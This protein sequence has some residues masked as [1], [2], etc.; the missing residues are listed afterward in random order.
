GPLAGMVEQV[1]NWNEP[2]SS[3]NTNDPPL[4]NWAPNSGIQQKALWQIGSSRVIDVATVQ[5]HSGSL[6]Q[7]EADLR[8]VA[9]HLEG[10]DNRIAWHLYPRGGV[11][12]NL[13]QQFRDLYAQVLGDYP[14]TCTEAGYF[15]AVN[16]TGGAIK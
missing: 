5:L 2:N 12:A 13:V 3:R 8:L 7:H 16:Y 6:T 10:Y 4:T 14:V 11:A 15:D 9:P 1:A